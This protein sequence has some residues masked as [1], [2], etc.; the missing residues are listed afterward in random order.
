ME[1]GVTEFL[2]LDKTIEVT[3]NDIYIVRKEVI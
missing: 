2:S 3:K 1:G